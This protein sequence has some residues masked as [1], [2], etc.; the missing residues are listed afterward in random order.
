MLA[1]WPIVFRLT[2][3]MPRM[4]QGGTPADLVKGTVAGVVL[5]LML[6]LPFLL[7]SPGAY[8]SRAF[9]LSR[10][11]LHVWSVNLKF[12]PEHVFQSKGLAA[13]LLLAHG[14]VLWL[15]ARWVADD[16]VQGMACSGAC[17]LTWRVVSFCLLYKQS[18]QG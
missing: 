13:G 17:Q 6:G 10:V 18:L 12:L 5:Q 3:A 16:W 1:C 14:I 9:E 7:H 4:I 8:L 11:F 2:A 15:F